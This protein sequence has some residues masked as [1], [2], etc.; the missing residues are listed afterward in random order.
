[1]TLSGSPGEFSPRAKSFRP[2]R[3]PL[4]VAPV[5]GVSAWLLAP[6]FEARLRELAS[7]Q[8][9]PAS[10]AECRETL[11]A[12]RAAS[13]DWQRWRRWLDSEASAD[14]RTEGPG[15][16]VAAESVPWIDTDEAAGLLGVSP[17]RV[18]Q[19]ARDGALRARRV[20]GRWQV[21]AGAVRLREG[22]RREA[23]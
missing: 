11:L 15:T 17:S 4:L 10:L 1:V 21:D 18:R 14:E 5:G 7:G 12:L 6:I 2:P 13:A 16:E 20:G 8:M 3:R 9:H 22:S 23:G 19:L